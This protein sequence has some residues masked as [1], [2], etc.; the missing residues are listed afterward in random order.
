MIFYANLYIFF[1]DTDITLWPSISFRLHH[2]I[3]FCLFV[4]GP[5]PGHI[6]VPRL[7]VKLELQ[8]PAYTTARATRDPSH[9]CSLHHSSWQCQI[10]NH[11]VRPGIEPTSSWILIGLIIAEPPWELLKLLCL[12]S[13]PV[14]FFLK[15]IEIDGWVRCMD[16]K[17]VWREWF[18]RAA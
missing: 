10:L 12:K 15:A 8:L 7:G 4:S 3:F 9:A 5:Y 17:K 18:R 2:T 1:I 14:S 6:E 16:L 11:W 13:C